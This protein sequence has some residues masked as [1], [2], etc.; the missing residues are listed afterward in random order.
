M[1]RAYRPDS[2]DYQLAMSVRNALSNPR[3]LQWLPATKRLLT[4][5]I[6]RWYERDFEPDGAIAF[7]KSYAPPPIL[8]AMIAAD[9]QKL[10]QDIPWDWSLNRYIP[11]AK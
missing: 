10:D 11:G 7:I 2:L 4:S 6:F 5:Q 9:V 8:D 3:H 1:P